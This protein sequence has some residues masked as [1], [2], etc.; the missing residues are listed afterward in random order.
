MKNRRFSLWTLLISIAVLIATLI[1]YFNDLEYNKK[2]FQLQIEKTESILRQ[3]LYGYEKLMLGA[4]ALF[5]ASSE[6]SSEEWS[7]YIRRLDLE[8]TAPGLNGIGVIFPVK[9]SDINTFVKQQRLSNH[10][11]FSYKPVPGTSNNDYDL[12]FVITYIQPLDENFAALGLDVGSE[13]NR[14]AALEVAIKNAEPTITHIIQLVQD[15]KIRPGFLLYYPIIVSEDTASKHTAFSLSGQKILGLV[16]APVISENLFN[17][18]LEDQGELLIGRVD[19]PTWAL[20]GHS[21]ELVY[22]NNAFRPELLSYKSSL[23]WHNQSFEIQWQK[24]PALLASEENSWFKILIFSLIIEILLLILIWNLD[25]TNQKQVE[26]ISDQKQALINSTRLSTL[27]EISAGIAHEINNPLGIVSGRAQQLQKNIQSSSYS[28]EKQEEIIVSMLNAI[29][30]I[31]KIIKGMRTLGRNT[32]FDPMTPVVVK[33]WIQETLD[34]CSQRLKGRGVRLEVEEIPLSVQVQGREAELSQVLL[35]LI[36]NAVDAIDELDEKWI[37]ITCNLDSVHVNINV[38][39]SGAGIPLEIQNK[40]L[41]AFFTTKSAGAGTGLGLSISQKIVEQ[42]NGT[43]KLVNS[44]P[45]TCFTITLPV[46]PETT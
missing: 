32:E 43:L 29:Q 16:Y 45:N 18:I 24:G 11:S 26:I 25:K 46:I 44:N 33:N 21:H 8:K 6:V 5:D 37:R 34:L 30:R 2:T 9:S 4:L 22:Q 23:Q 7:R 15:N 35:N 19:W 28:Q 17:D 41:N 14:R 38:M 10:K 31:T 40:V 20:G 12:S 1:S 36:N 13:G 3:R 27:G 39:D 42:H